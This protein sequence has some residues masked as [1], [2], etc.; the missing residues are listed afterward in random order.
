MAAGRWDGAAWLEEQAALAE[1]RAGLLRDDL[2]V[3]SW[4]N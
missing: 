4:R 1:H 2:L 3:T